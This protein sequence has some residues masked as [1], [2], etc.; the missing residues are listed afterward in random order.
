MKLSDIKGE[1]ALD[2]IADIV[3]AVVDLSKNEN[4]AAVF[5]S[6]GSGSREDAMD[7]VR[8]F[9]PALVRDERDKFVTIMSTIEGTTPEEYT[10][11]LTMAK[12]ISDVM[13]IL[14]DDALLAFLK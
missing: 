12:L 7:L 9:V 4:V 8:G 11:N 2:V 14:T 10:E 1:R 5:N 6:R 3:P 13:D